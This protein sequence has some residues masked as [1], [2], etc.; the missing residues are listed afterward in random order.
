MEN[1]DYYKLVQ[2][3]RQRVRK[4]IFSTG[5]KKCDHTMDLVGCSI[6][7]LLSHLASQFQPGMTF[8]NH[9]EWHIDHII[10]CAVFNLTDPEQQKACFHYSNLQPLWAEENIRKGGRWDSR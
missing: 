5:S 2:C 7:E 9:G 4:A 10:P 1:A 3:L 8:E 6:L